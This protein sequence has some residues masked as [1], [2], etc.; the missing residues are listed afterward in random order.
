MLYF[1]TISELLFPVSKLLFC[2][3]SQSPSSFLYLRASILL[4]QASILRLLVSIL[5]IQASILLLQAS[6]LA[7]SPSFIV[8]SKLLSS[9]SKLLDSVFKLLFYPCHH[10]L[11]SLYFFY[12]FHLS[13]PFSSFQL[14][15]SLSAS[16]IL[17]VFVSSCFLWLSTVPP[18]FFHIRFSLNNLLVYLSLHF[19]H[20]PPKSSILLLFAWLFVPS[21]LPS[22]YSL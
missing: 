14:L 2:I 18:I 19:L 11:L 22:I 15:L 17:S 16:W 7:P 8:F 10:F 4:L 9:F 3:Y 5:G 6:I 20:F 1:S 21:R 12:F 13:S